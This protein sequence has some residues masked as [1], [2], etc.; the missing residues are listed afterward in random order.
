[1]L[2]FWDE[3]QLKNNFN[4]HIVNGYGNLCA[5]VL[6]LIDVN[7]VDIYDYNNNLINTITND[8]VF[9][10]KKGVYKIKYK[11]D[12]LVYPDS[13]MFYDVWNIT[14]NNKTI[15]IRNDFFKKKKSKFRINFY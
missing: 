7:H 9:F 13:V 15:E 5:R 1:M 14:I 2:Y 8:D 4:S 10:V 3:N 11:V 12:S 6:H